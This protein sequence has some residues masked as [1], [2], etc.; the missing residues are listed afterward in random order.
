MKYRNPQIPEGINTSDRHPLKEFATLAGGAVLLIVALGWLMGQV[1]GSL[2]GLLPFEKE[3][4]LVPKELLSSDAGP[5]LQAYLD[6]LAARLGQDMDLPEGMQ[7]RV[8]FSGN[9]TFNAFA[10]LGGNILLFRGLVEALPHENALSMLLAHEIAHVLHRDPIVGIGRGA[11]IRLVTGLLLGSPDLAVLGSA[12]IYTQL[13]YS[14]GMERAADAAALRAVHQRYGHIGG[15]AELFNI[16]RAERE[17]SG[18]GEMPAFFSSHPLDLDRLQTITATA[19][20][21]GWH[22]NGQATPLPA[23]FNDWM[24]DAAGRA[25]RPEGQRQV[26]SD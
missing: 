1:A 17:R 11:A 5:E 14:R 21:Q 4:A 18:G 9:D 25:A 8:H 15:A 7:V 3:M 2:A 16:L 23:A 6:R 22:E 24:Q 26:R 20:Q 12:G 19:R 10:T 13:H